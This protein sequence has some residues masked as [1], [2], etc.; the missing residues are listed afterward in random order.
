VREQLGLSQEE[1]PL[2]KVLQGG[3]WSLGRKMAKALRSDGRPPILIES[4]GT[5]F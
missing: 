1:L 4:D 5:I 2:G 3:T